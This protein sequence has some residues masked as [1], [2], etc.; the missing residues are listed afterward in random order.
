MLYIMLA[1]LV[2]LRLLTVPSSP[3]SFKLGK[4]KHTISVLATDVAGNA[5]ASPA[6]VQV[7]VKKKKRKKKKHQA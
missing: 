5:D 4:G 3:A 1:T 7:Q 6:T 2:T